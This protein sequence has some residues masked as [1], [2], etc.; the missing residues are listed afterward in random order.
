M[1]ADLDDA[2]FA[3]W[4]QARAQQVARETVRGEAAKL[5]ALWRWCSEPRRG[6]VLAPE[7]TA[8]EQFI[9]VPQALDATQL[10]SLWQCAASLQGSVGDVPASIYWPALLYMLW[11]TSERITP[12]H[13][14]SRED[15]QGRWLTVYPHSRKGRV[16]FGRAY[17][18]SRAGAAAIRKLLAATPVNQPF[19]LLSTNALYKQF[20][21]IRAT[22]EMPQWCTFHT[23]RRSHASHL[24]AAGGDAR[25]SLGHSSDAVTDRSYRDPRICAGGSRQPSDLLFDPL[26]WW[27]RM[28]ARWSG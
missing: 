19:Q 25:Q 17:K 2:V 21:R 11:D 7:I 23:I 22:A 27:H 8:P 12:V 5:L 26:G 6:W 16:K 20:R 28:W 14:F 24:T 15:L 10:R 18:I 13:R 4:L 1:V 9:Q 3:G